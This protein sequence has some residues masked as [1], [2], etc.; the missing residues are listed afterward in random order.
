MLANDS[1]RDIAFGQRDGD[2]KANEPGADYDY[3]V[4]QLSASSETAPGG[5]A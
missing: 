3:V 4:A 2:C 1:Y 5:V